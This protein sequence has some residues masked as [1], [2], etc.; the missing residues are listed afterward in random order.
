VVGDTLYGAA[1]EI[2]SKAGMPLSLTRNFLH[3]AQIE[4]DHPR[5]G[6]RLSF[7]VPIPKRLDEFLASVAA[8]SG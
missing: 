2:I 1:R 8:V 3:A 4:F 5:T 7:S 6:E